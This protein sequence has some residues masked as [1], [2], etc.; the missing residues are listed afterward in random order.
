[1]NLILASSSPRR[2]E[3][4]D[5]LDLPYEARSPDGVDESTVN[6]AAYS[7]CQ[8]RARLKAEWV[9]SQCDTEADHVVVG[10]DTIVVIVRGGQE[11]SLGKPKDE[12]EARKML[13]TL[14]GSV[15]RVASA[16]AIAREGVPTRVAVE[17]S[18]VAFRQLTDDA[19]EAYVRT[20]DPLDK[21][22][23]YGIQTRGHDLVAS[24]RGC[25]LNIV[26]LPVMLMCEML[27]VETSY[28]CPCAEHQLQTCASGCKLG[29]TCGEQA[30]D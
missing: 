11:R 9:L 10:C 7:V 17:I 3:L 2:R 4:L 14:S 24:I 8:E 15:H 16:I 6:G 21:A 27:G 28:R 22:G 1:M 5:Q 19:I 29:A 12:G 30:A 23:A 25:Y 20:G 26:G 13:R 18:H